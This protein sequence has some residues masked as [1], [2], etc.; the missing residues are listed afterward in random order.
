MASG[1]LFGSSASRSQG[2]YLVEFRAGKMYMKGNMVHPD[3]RKGL[4]YVYQSDDSLMHFCWK[5]R[6]KNT[7]DDD[8]II[9]PDDCEFKRVKQCTT[10]RVYLLKFKSTAR[11]MFFWMQEPKTD[12]D[13]EYAQ[14]VNDNLN[15]PPT[16]GQSRS[17]GLGALGGLPPELAAGL[18]GESELSSMLGNMSQQQLMQLLGGMGGM[19]GLSA[20]MGGRPSSSMSDSPAPSRVQSSPG[21]RNTQRSSDDKSNRPVTAAAL[22]SQTPKS[23]GASRTQPSTTIASTSAQPAAQ[24]EASESSGRIQLSDLK[25]IITGMEGVEDEQMNLASVI[26]PEQIAPV[27]ANP[28]IQAR[29]KPY[30][31]EGELLPQTEGEVINTLSTPQFQQAMASFGAAL[32]SGQLGPLMGQFGLGEDVANAAA[33]GD[34]HAFAKAMQEAQKKEQEKKG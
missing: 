11:K 4:V 19:G 23:T 20:L 21:P 17:G 10:G 8:L 1:A 32:A 6:T 3:K 28:D 18:G 22:P 29:L 2:K 25:K 27:L 7:V 14:K 30:L 9:F 12:K 31:P 16:P 15:N 33:A 26:S 24:A 5:D 34:V 13:E